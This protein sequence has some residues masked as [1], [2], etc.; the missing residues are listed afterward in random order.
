M[1]ECESTKELKQDDGLGFRMVNNRQKD[2]FCL[3]DL[4]VSR[5]SE[6]KQNLKKNR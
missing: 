6:N 2:H 5:A 3:V 4:K 1:N